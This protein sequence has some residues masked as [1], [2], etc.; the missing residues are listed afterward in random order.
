MAERPVK[1]QR[2]ESQDQSTAAKQHSKSSRSGNAGVGQYFKPPNVTLTAENSNPS[3][4]IDLTLDDDDDDD[5]FQITEVRNLA[6]QEV[7]YGMI[8]GTIQA[9]KIPKPQQNNS[10]AAA[11][12]QWPVFKIMVERL[13]DR[14]SKKVL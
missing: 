2:L 6:D 9:H 8:D 12:N 14:V 10:F 1:R 5:G 3:D 7:C 4:A 11:H 13:T